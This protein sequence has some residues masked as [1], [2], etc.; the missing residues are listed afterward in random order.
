MSLS[1]QMHDSDHVTDWR[2]VT[3]RQVAQQFSLEYC[4]LFGWTVQVRYTCSSAFQKKTAPPVEVEW[5]AL[6]QKSNSLFLHVQTKTWSQLWRYNRGTTLVWQRRE[7]CFV[8][9]TSGN[10]VWKYKLIIIMMIFGAVLSTCSSLTCYT[11]W[12][13]LLEF[14]LRWFLLYWHRF[15]SSN[16]SL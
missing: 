4:F 12:F 14:S 9:P 11:R 16:F 7:I 8:Y 15:R 6:S 5:D 3:V 2:P 13:C 1:N 10:Q